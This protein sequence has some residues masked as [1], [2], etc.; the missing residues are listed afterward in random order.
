MTKSLFWKFILWILPVILVL[1]MIVMFIAYNYV[2]NLALSKYK[3]NVVNVANLAAKYFENFNPYDA[4]DARSCNAV[5]D[6]LCEKLGLSYVYAL[7]PDEKNDTLTY[8]SIGYGA[9]ASPKVKEE[10]YPGVVVKGINDQQKKAIDNEDLDGT[11]FFKNDFGETIVSYAPVTRYYDAKKEDFVDKTVSIVGAEMTV[12]SVRSGITRDFLIIAL[13]VFISSNIIAFFIAFMVYRK[14]SRPIR[15]ISRRMTHFVTDR[16]KEFVEMEVKGKDEISE[17]TKSFNMMAEEIDR[18][19]DDISALNKEKNIQ[20]AEFN[21]AKKI[22]MGLLPLDECV[23]DEYCIYAYLHS[24]KEVGGDLYNYKV[25]ESGKLCV[26]IADVSGKGVAASIF[27]TRG[28]TLINQLSAAGFSPKEILEKY[29]SVLCSNNPSGMF[30]TTFLGIYDPKTM[31]FTYTNGGH[32]IPYLISDGLKKLEGAHCMAAGLF[33]D[34][35]YEQETIK[36]K[37][38]DRI[39]M[40]TDGVNEAENKDNKFFGTERLEKL[41]IENSDKI[42]RDLIESIKSGIAGFVGGAHQSDDITMLVL[43]VFGSDGKAKTE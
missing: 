5:F 32:N 36:L 31:E 33:D 13:F 30:I 1:E 14:I 2:Y 26:A 4:D 10:R 43:T 29:N 34:E 42:G 35:I 15:E 39:F 25:L 23:N 37:P 19:I 16:D 7:M 27:M 40:Y 18:Y 41:L 20:E 9:D 8:L 12:S 11:M 28:L 24:A 6:E 21:I 22:Q 17:M 38:G 3:E